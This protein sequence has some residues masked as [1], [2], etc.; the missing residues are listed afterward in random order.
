MRQM[1]TYQRRCRKVENVSSGEPLIVFA[2]ST[3]FF[4]GL[5]DPES[6]FLCR[7]DFFLGCIRLD[8]EYCQII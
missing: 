4:G 7:D 5:L 1:G 3:K 8:F 2:E 6:T